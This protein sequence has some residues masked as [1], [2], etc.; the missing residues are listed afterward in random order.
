MDV[1]DGLRGMFFAGWLVVEQDILPRGAERFARAAEEQR[2]NRAFLAAR[3][4]DWQ[5]VRRQSSG[6]AGLGFPRRAAGPA[7]LPGLAG[8]PPRVAERA[9]QQELDLGV[10]AAQLVGGPPGQR[11]VNGRIEPKQHALALAH[12][13]TVPAVTGRGSRC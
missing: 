9:A 10:G 2:L 1:L 4:C 3:G 8:H 7:H 12:R 6:S 13:G 5:A 11:V